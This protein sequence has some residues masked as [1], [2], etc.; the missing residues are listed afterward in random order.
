[1]HI[2]NAEA[3]LSWPPFLHYV[4]FKPPISKIELKKGKEHG[5]INMGA[6]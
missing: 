4:A 1:M 6:S 3:K 2:A 5:A